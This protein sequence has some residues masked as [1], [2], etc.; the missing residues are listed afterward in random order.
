[1]GSI[2][3]RETVCSSIGNQNIPQYEKRTYRDLK[4]CQHS[5]Q[6]CTIFKIARMFPRT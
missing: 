3:S 6:S 5:P 1:M 4:S 2:S